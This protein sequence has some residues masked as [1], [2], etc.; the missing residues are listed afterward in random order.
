MVH[1]VYSAPKKRARA[2]PA[3]ATGMLPSKPAAMFVCSGSSGVLVTVAVAVSVEIGTRVLLEIG[4]LVGMTWLDDEGV[5]VGDTALT[6]IK[7]RVMVV[8]RVE[9][10]VSSAPTSWVAPRK[11]T[12]ETIALSFILRKIAMCG[13]GLEDRKGFLKEGFWLR[14]DG[15]RSAS[16]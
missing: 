2:P 10:R 7:V 3:R 15:V 8:V 13:S 6:R 14:L 11:R 12:V 4:W 1:N 9:V 16:G 5:A